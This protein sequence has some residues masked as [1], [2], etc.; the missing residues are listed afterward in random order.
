MNGS[1]DCPFAPKSISMKERMAA[2][3]VP[4]TNL[5]ILTAITISYSNKNQEKEENYYFWLSR[6]MMA[7]ELNIKVE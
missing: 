7:P 4:L 2:N 6:Y 5:P 3:G 1:I